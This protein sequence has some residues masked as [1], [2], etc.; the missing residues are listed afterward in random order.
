MVGNLSSSGFKLKLWQPFLGELAAITQFE[1]GCRLFI[2][3]RDK[4]CIPFKMPVS[5]RMALGVKR[6]RGLDF[7]GKAVA[8]FYAAEALSPQ[9]GP[10][11]P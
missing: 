10:G 6:Y 1:S 11:Y 2:S 3:E 7:V 5:E 9:G 8:K 4:Q